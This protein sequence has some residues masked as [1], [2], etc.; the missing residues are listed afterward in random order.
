VFKSALID[1]KRIFEEL[2][3]VTMHID[4]FVVDDDDDDD[5]DDT[6]TA[7]TLQ[8]MQDKVKVSFI[9]KNNSVGL[10]FFLLFLKIIHCM[11][12]W[13]HQNIWHCHIQQ[14]FKLF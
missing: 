11:F 9:H 7:D 4:Y 12:M 6:G 2:H 1:V 3:Q 8:M 5:A 13:P 10:C 14:C